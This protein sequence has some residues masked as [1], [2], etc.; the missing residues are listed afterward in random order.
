MSEELER[1]QDRSE[2]I[3][4]LEA[5]LQRRVARRIPPSVALTALVVGAALLW[6][7]RLELAYFFSPSTPLTLGHEGDYRY[8][9][10]ASNRY[11][12]LHGVPTARAAW[13][14]AGEEG[15]VIVG[16]RESP[17]LVLRAALPGEE[18]KPGQPP[19]PPDSTPFAVRGRL[20]AEEQAAR[21]TEALALHRQWGE[22]QPYQGRLWLLVQGER[23]GSELGLLAVA[24]LIL[25]FM[26]L[27]AMW[28]WRAVAASRPR[29]SPSGRG[30]G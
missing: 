29:P 27:N 7:M 25:L 24:S 12:Q 19:P 28:L 17:F 5:R 26:A 21:Y 8:E 10:L 1:Q 15:A 11:V 13:L 23:P 2:R 9:L 4:E 16:L 18:W 20:L 6:M 30:T 22:V 14:G 3:A